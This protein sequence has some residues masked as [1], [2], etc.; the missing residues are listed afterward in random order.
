[1][2]TLWFIV[3]Y[4]KHYKLF[5]FIFNVNFMCIE[6]DKYLTSIE[7][8]K[9]KLISDL[10]IYK[11]YI[12]YG[13]DTFIIAV[14][15][16]N[17]ILGCFVFFESDENYQLAHMCVSKQLQRQGIGKAIM[18]GAVEEWSY[19]KLPSLNRRDKYHYNENG[20]QFI[21]HCFNKEI[22][23]TPPFSRPTEYVMI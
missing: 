16:T 5:K 20:L 8:N 7:Q 14:D 2:K 12:Y 23:K 6:V 19:F 11:I 21:H 9:C 10:D 15:R 1:M 4:S 13:Y 3:D 17:L 22:L 18:K